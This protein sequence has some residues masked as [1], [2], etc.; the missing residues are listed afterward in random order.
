LEIHIQ[1]VKK[2]AVKL[3]MGMKIILPDSSDRS[4]FAFPFFVIA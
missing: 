3:Y 1:P 2:S 4:E